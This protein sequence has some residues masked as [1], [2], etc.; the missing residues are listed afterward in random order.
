MKRIASSNHMFLCGREDLYT[1]L[2][3]DE[4]V[5]YDHH[6]HCPFILYYYYCYCCGCCWHVHY[7]PLKCFYF[8]LF[9]SGMYIT[10]IVLLI[11][12]EMLIPYIGNT[13]INF[14]E[15]RWIFFATEIRKAWHNNEFLSNNWIMTAKNQKKVISTKYSRHHHHREET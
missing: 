15:L 9:L 12:S 2:W 13:E 1:I 6:H 7:L 5:S 10:S 3:W 11:F 14:S 4:N 8:C